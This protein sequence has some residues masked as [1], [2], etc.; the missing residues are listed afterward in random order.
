ML[1]PH[2]APAGSSV[3]DALQTN[4]DAIRAADGVPHINHPNFGWAIADELATVRNNRL[5]RSP[6][7][8]E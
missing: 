2:R 7:I 5:S 1:A 6:G 4:V 8:R 3:A